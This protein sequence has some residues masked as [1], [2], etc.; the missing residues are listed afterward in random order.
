[1][2]RAPNTGGGQKWAVCLPAN[3]A[4]TAFLTASPDHGPAPLTV[5]FTGSGTDPDAGDTI[6]SYTFDF[7]DGTN[8]VTQ[9]S[10]MVSHTYNAPGEYRARLDVT[11]SRGLISTNT[12]LVAIEVNA[13]L[14]NLSTR[15]FVQTDDN[16]LIAGF[17]VNGTEPRQ[18]LLRGIGPSTKVNGQP[19]PGAMQDPTIEL[20]DANGV[21]ATNDN[22]KINDQT[23]QSQQAA[24]Q[25]TGAAPSDDRE[26]AI[27]RTLNP[28]NY[29]VVLRGKANSTG[30]A[31]VEA[32]DLDPFA[33][34]KLANIS[35]RG[36]VQTGDNR[37]IAGFVAGPPNAAP[38]GVLIRGMGPSLANFGV[39]NPLQNPTLELHDS[40]GTT[41]RMNDDWTSD[42]Q[43]DIQATGL[44]P[45]N[46]SEAA[47]LVDVAPG[48]YT[49]ILA[50]KNGGTGVGLVE[51]YN[52]H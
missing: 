24:I 8:P 31:V 30:V 43:A 12:A 52:V 6:A 21:I 50:G 13:A 20:H 27:V 3:A 32:F 47:I 46:N 36:F 22:W 48:A 45:Q 33:N 42:Q 2:D 7:G 9:S 40:N 17:I 1:M 11:D 39:P 49:A 25:N 16:V 41:L 29:T 23:G 18:I 44:A 15:G 4:P 37:V 19:V 34:S 38:T 35:T 51:I 14:R 26:S 5:M 28:G 10:P